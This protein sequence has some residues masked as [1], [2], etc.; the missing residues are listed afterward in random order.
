MSRRSIRA[1]AIAVVLAALWLGAGCVTA[2]GAA[3]RFERLL[4]PELY[5]FRYDADTQ[6]L[7]V[8]TRSG[9]VIE[10]EGVAAETV[11]E[12]RRAEDRDAFYRDQIKAKWPGRPMDLSAP[13]LPAP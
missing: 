8:V 11:A 12:W 2:G 6:R 3:G 13:A 7:T 1:A 10:H 9:D 5:S 4:T